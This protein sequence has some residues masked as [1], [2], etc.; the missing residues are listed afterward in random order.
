MAK[1]KKR[2][3]GRYATSIIIGYQDDGKPKR[4][5]LYGKTIR[6]LDN[7][8]SDFKSLQNK[9]IIINDNSMTMAQWA[10]KWL[11]LYKQNKAYNTYIMYKN[12]VNTHII[13]SIG[14]MR[15]SS[16]KK[17]HLQ[18]L[19]NN[20]V[21]DGKLCVAEIVRLTLKQIIQT[22][23]EEQY[24]YVDISNKLSLPQRQAKEK[25]VLTD[26]E[27]RII[28]NADLS[29]KQRAFIDLLY[30]T[31][32]RRGEALA[33]RVSDFDFVNKKV[34]VNKTIIFKG[35]EPFV[36]YTPK[37]KAGI[38]EIP[39]PDI[40]IKRLKQYLNES[41]NISYIFTQDTNT[42]LMTVSSFRKFWRGIIKATGLPNDIT[43]HILRHT[44]ATKLYYA[45]VDLK[46][47][48]YL[49]GH[50]NIKITLD[51]YTHLDKLKVNDISDKINN[52]F[53]YG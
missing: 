32:M 24:I 19:L 8:V 14:D 39:M 37:T 10:Q 23:I 38:R 30:Y 52:I 47:A 51:I 36:E 7:K 35:N 29:S 41:S 45:G 3:D 13:P 34:C 5:V 53:N 6:E 4:K 11:K 43:P 42:N 22:A 12:A 49:L 44:Y 15:L 26:D 25:R 28:S 18:E 1:Y 9:G 46:T 33:L 31:G 48:Q 2:K 21:A 20:I 27:V 16:L 17:N 40:L 50:S